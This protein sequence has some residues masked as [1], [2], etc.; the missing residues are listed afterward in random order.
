MKIALRG[1]GSARFAKK[2]EKAGIADLVGG[3][4]N[5]LF[6]DSSW[7]NPRL[8]E[9][10]F[11]AAKKGSFDLN[12]WMTFTPKDLATAEFHQVR[13]RKVVEDS[14][15]D[16]E[17]MFDDIELLP[18]IGNDPKRRY[19]IQEQVFLS[20]IRLKPNQ[21]AVVGQWTAEY[22]VPGLVRKL[23]EDARFDGIEF[24]PVIN[25]RTGLPHD[26]YFH[27]YSGHALGA[28]ELDIASPEIESNRAEEQGYDSLGCLC[29]EPRALKNARDFNRTGEPMVGFRF[30][31]WVVRASVSELFRDRKLRGWAFEP[32]LDVE[33]E[34]YRDYTELWSSFYRMLARCVRHT[35]HCRKIESIGNVIH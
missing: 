31:G 25:T 18:W 4:H 10:L 1:M 6:F 35:V 27:L 34:T 13:T 14:Q 3:I 15:K 2:L 32:V 33:S 26:D 7:P 5:E 24:R 11:E 23:F 29:Y 17:R 19:K 30:P 16:Y 28:R 21:V 22:V 12:P 20:N 8:E 9:F